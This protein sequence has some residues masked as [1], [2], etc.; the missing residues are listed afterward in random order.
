MVHTVWIVAIVLVALASGLGAV[1]AAEG[2]QQSEEMK[3]M[4]EQLNNQVMQAPFSVPEESK[5]KAYI[6]EQQKLGVVP[7]PYT[8]RYWRP[9]YTCY[10]LARYS[11]GEYLACR[12]YHHYYGYY[13][14]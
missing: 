6:E 9:G 1:G 7:P 12:H 4:Q 2:Q 13:Y 11:S 5:V 8:G 3:R 10:N 14:R